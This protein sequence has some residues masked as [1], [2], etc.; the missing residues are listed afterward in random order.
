MRVI[1]L[2][3]NGYRAAVKKGL[4]EFLETQQADIICFQELKAD[5]SNLP[6]SVMNYHTLW[7]PAER[8]GY[9]GVGLL[10]KQEP[11]AVHMGMGVK[12]YD[13]EGRVLRA[14]LNTPSGELSIVSVYIPSGS[15]GDPRQAFKMR[16]LK[17]F[18]RYLKTLL[19]EGH[20]VI[21]C[22]DY[23]I[24]HQK[25]DLKNWQSNQK[26]SGFLPEERKWLDTTLKLGLRDAYREHIGPDATSYSWWSLRSGARARNVG[27]R[28]D[29]QLTSP[30]LAA[31]VSAAEIPMEPIL[32]DHAPVVVAYDL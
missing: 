6:E 3:L 14:D 16:F 22:G 15:S 32:S 18:K 2:N 4:L 13:C 7:H 10:L 21:V 25:I 26:T 17:A 12:I 19:T 29:Y 11:H 27:W 23:N 1:S 8:K 20:K 24:A 9:S 30:E 31:A 28:L 5:L